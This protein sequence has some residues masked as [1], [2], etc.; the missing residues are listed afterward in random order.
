MVEPNATEEDS[1]LVECKLRR[2]RIAVLKQASTPP[3]L[4]Q[5]RL[6]PA[7][8]SQIDDD[9]QLSIDCVDSSNFDEEDADSTTEENS[10][11]IVKDK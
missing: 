10:S 2:P 6:K 9:I 4:L 8:D 11:R 5:G 3:S 7:N 1:R